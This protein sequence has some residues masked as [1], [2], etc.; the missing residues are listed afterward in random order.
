M[1]RNVSAKGV[2]NVGRVYLHNRDVCA[3]EAV[4]RLTNMHLNEYSW[5]VVSVPA[6][7]NVER[8]SL[9]INLLRQKAAS[10]DLLTENKW[11]TSIVDVITIGQMRVFLMIQSNPEVFGQ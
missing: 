2:K 10:Q 5:Q 4:Y 8:I 9:S 1:Q 7:D 3:V 6:R 11:M